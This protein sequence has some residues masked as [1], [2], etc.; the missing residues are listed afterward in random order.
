MIALTGCSGGSFY[1]GDCG[2]DCGTVCEDVC[3]NVPV[4]C[5]RVE[6]RADECVRVERRTDCARVERVRNECVRNECVRD[7]C[8]QEAC[9]P[10][11]ATC[12]VP[13]KCIYPSRNELN[14]LDGITVTA[15]NPE[16]CILGDQYPLAFDVKACDDVCDVV[17]RTLLPE[18]VTFIRSQPEAT[19]EGRALIWHLGSMRKGQCVP[20]RV[21]LKCECEGELC[22]C[23]CASATPVR[24]CSL[25]CAKP[26]LVCHKCGPEECAP[27]DPINY[28]V[29]VT[30]RGSCTA[31]GV[32]VTDNVPDGLEHAS[33]LRTLT[34]NLGSLEPCETKKINMC[35]TA[36]RR[37]EVCN[38]A[39]VT[40]CNAEPVS[41]TAKC[42]VCALC[43]EC[44]KV[45]PREM[46]IGKNADYTI[47][48]ANTGD[49]PLTEVV[50]TDTAPSATSIV[51]APG[52][53][54]CGNQAVWRMRQLDPGERVSFN[55]TLT[56][57]T[58]GCFTNRASF[59][60]AEGCN[61]CCELT[62]R[63]RGRPA[64][65]MCISDTCDPVCI[66]DTTTYNI[67]VTNQGS[68]AD[69]DVRVV[70]RFPQ[71]VEPVSLGGDVQGT[72]DGN[73]VTFRP[74]GNFAPRQ[75]ISYRIQAKAR[76][77]GDARIVAEVSSASIKK[78]IVQQESTIVN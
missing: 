19:V 75:T 34:F 63:W 40:A 7:E 31:T 21:W 43:G 32:V 56:T 48:V 10:C 69:Q 51:T 12:K 14:C 42:I 3:N 5:A 29:T 28:T 57:C 59:V 41:C 9:V 6:R 36:C 22:A 50:V 53:R 37:G 60:N 13:A 25:L 46:A 70:V 44:E 30:N 77:S 38:T 26:V 18:G 55:I 24:F 16:M 49:K 66:G 76:A 8:V 23:F 1:S 47:T 33:G 39:T 20:A 71:E 58:P 2:N 78:P 11:E 67:S 27:G 52:A 62:T 54:V 35:F 4:E 68:E 72:I 65:T 17:V 73:T 64:L 45:G 74:Y 15:H 61:E